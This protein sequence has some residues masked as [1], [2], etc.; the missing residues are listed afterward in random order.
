MNCTVAVMR[1]GAAS[2]KSRRGVSN[3]TLVKKKNLRAFSDFAQLSL[4][5][6]KLYVVALLKIF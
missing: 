4:E 2:H 5:P 1:P 6:Q 3:K